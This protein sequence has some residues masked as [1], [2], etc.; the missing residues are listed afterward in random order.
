MD[1]EERLV[2]QAE[3]I[4]AINPDTKVYVYRNLVK[5]DQAR[6]PRIPWLVPRVQAGRLAAERIVPRTAMHR[7]C[8]GTC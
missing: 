4:K 7:Q 3:V 1:C 8:G 5:E 6:R 2:Q